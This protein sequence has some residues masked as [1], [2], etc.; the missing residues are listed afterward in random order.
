MAPSVVVLVH[1]EADRA[2]I[3]AS[4]RVAMAA[5]GT[6]ASAREA[7]DLVVSAKAYSSKVATAAVGTEASGREASDLVVS[8]KVG[9]SVTG[10]SVKEVPFPVASAAEVSDPAASAREAPSR[11]ASVASDKAA[12]I[13]ATSG[14]AATGTKG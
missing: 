7:S 11:V 12:L 10:A 9:P 4:S 1:S 13:L 8:G 3:K 2:S 14:A 6:E 5:A